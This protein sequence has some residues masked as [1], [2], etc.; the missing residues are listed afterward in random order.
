MMLVWVR[1][2]LIVIF[3]LVGFNLLIRDF[4]VTLVN[5]VFCIYVASLRKEYIKQSK[6]IISTFYLNT[7][8][9]FN[10]SQFLKNLGRQLLFAR[11]TSCAI[12]IYLRSSPNQN[13]WHATI[14]VGPNPYLSISSRLPTP[15]ICW[16]SCV[17]DNQSYSNCKP[18]FTISIDFIYGR[19]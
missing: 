12:S 8:V 19:K 1:D 15:I 4:L 7:R 11:T 16:L 13:P 9:G 5:Y 18:K 6:F 17:W 2:F 3:L 10:L 14:L